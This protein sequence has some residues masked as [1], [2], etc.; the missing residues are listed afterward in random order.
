M[1]T[2]DTAPDPLAHKWYDVLPTRGGFAI[3][4]QWVPQTTDSSPLA[5]FVMLDSKR[6]RTVYRVSEFPV[7]WAGRGFTFA[8]IKGEGT[9]KTVENYNVFAATA[10]AAHDG[11]DCKSTARWGYC[12]H[13]DAVRTLINNSWL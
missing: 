7:S 11:C 5:G 2:T 10:G 9:D 6:D 13:S 4:M 8:K 3:A 12:K 1:P